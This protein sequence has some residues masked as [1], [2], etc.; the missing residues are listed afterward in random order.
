[1]SIIEQGNIIQTAAEPLR[2]AVRT[3]T[4]AELLALHT[5]PIELVAAPG[6][7]RYLQVDFVVSHKAAGVAYTGIGANDDLEI[8]YT[9]AS[10]TELVDVETL[11]FLDQGPPETRFSAAGRGAEI[12]PTLNAP[13][14]VVLGGAITVG[15]CE[16]E[17]KV[18]YRVMEV[19]HPDKVATV[20]L[21][22]AEILALHTT[23]VEVLPAVHGKGLNIRGI[24]AVKPAGTA[25]ANI[26]AS[27]DLSFRYGDASGTELVSVETAT[28]LG[29]AGGQ[30]LYTGGTNVTVEDN[31]PVVVSLPGAITTGDSDVTLTIYYREE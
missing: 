28:L 14:V 29:S 5:T 4:A 22:S 17:L 9:N 25:Y 12:E 2:L 7:N 21:T 20:V 27:E 13:L 24:N 31:E 3:L 19:P 23:P 26:A 30:T 11:G 10:G 15:N 6:G 18:Y 8:R 1:M 16:L